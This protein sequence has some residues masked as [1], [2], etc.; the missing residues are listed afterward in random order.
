MLQEKSVFYS[1]IFS[2]NLSLKIQWMIQI[3]V[4]L[5]VISLMKHIVPKSHNVPLLSIIAFSSS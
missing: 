1:N 4:L 3:E 2:S 5:F